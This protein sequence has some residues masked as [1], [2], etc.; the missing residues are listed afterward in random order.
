MAALPMVSAGMGTCV[1]TF[2]V[3]NGCVGVVGTPMGFAYLWVVSVAAVALAGLRG[4]VISDQ[5][6]CGFATPVGAYFT[7]YSRGVRASRER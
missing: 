3:K 2:R 1:D 5:S 7:A 6:V 4:R